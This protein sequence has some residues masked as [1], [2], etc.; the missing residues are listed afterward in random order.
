MFILRRN[1]LFICLAHHLAD[2]KYKKIFNNNALVVIGLNS[3]WCQLFNWITNIPV[4]QC[5]QK[6]LQK[7][8][9][10]DNKPICKRRNVQILK[11]RGKTGFAVAFYKIIRQSK[12]ETNTVRDANYFTTSKINSMNNTKFCKNYEQASLH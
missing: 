12:S 10:L 2:M 5:V 1:L 9:V 3:L 11:K 6:V 8:W 7:V 4:L